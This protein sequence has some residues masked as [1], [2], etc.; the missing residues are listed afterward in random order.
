[1]KELYK[2]LLPAVLAAPL[3]IDGCAKKQET[4]FVEPAQQVS[5]QTKVIKGEKIDLKTGLIDINDASIPQAVRDRF[6]KL[7]PMKDEKGEIYCHANSVKID[8]QPAVITSGHCSRKILKKVQATGM[9][10]APVYSK[11]IK[12]IIDDKPKLTEL[13]RLPRI[14]EGELIYFAIPKLRILSDKED[15]VVQGMKVFVG[16]ARYINTSKGILLAT[17]EEAPVFMVNAD[18]SSGSAISDSN[19]KLVGTL[20]GGLFANS[21]TGVISNNILSSLPE[22]YKVGVTGIPIDRTKKIIKFN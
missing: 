21:K 10:D 20:Y 15:Y 18:G 17:S 8:K 5:E 3:S 12:N 13:F 1:M 16:H 4:T 11:T 2:F 9:E 19:G 6:L 7:V 22:Y 14:N